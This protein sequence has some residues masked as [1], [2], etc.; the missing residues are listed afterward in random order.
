MKKDRSCGKKDTDE[1]GYCV[2]CPP[3]WRLAWCHC[4][5]CI[6]HHPEGRCPCYLKGG[7]KEANVTMFSNSAKKAL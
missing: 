6:K 1:C 5:T 7:C 4:G 2:A 3:R